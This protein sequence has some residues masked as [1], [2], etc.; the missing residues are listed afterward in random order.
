LPSFSKDGE[1]TVQKAVVVHTLIEDGVGQ[2]W[3]IEVDAPGSAT[4]QPLKQLLD[5]GWRIVQTCSLHSDLDGTCLLVLEKDGPLRPGQ[6]VS[7]AELARRPDR[8]RVQSDSPSP[9]Q[10]GWDGETIPLT[11]FQPS[12]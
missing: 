4:A 1:S 11:A 12:L 7:L 9:E 6:D 3:S 5:E 2:S 8:L 10:T